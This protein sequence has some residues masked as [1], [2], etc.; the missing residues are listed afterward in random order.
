MTGE[1]RS[2]CG[3]IGV[4][5]RLL[6][7]IPDRLSYGDC[8]I[9]PIKHVMRLVNVHIDGRRRAAAR[10]KKNKDVQG[11]ATTHDWR[12]E[13]AALEIASKARFYRVKVSNT[14]GQ[15]MDIKHA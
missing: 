9:A 2:S 15:V 12:G 8:W 10:N 7:T 5:H 11:S 1:N 3:Q 13:A 4:S 6:W 14:V